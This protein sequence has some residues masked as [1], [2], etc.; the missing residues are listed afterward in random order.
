[1][2]GCWATDGGWLTTRPGNSGDRLRE[3]RLPDMACLCHPAPISFW[4][5]DWFYYRAGVLNW[6]QLCPPGDIWQCWRH[7]GRHSGGVLLV[8]SGRRPRTL[9]TPSHM[10]AGTCC[11]PGRCSLLEL[12]AQ[13][14]QPVRSSWKLH[15]ECNDQ[16]SEGEW[17]RFLLAPAPEGHICFF[18]RPLKLLFLSTGLTSPF[19]SVAA[20]T[21]FQKI[22]FLLAK[23]K[24]VLFL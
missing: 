4:L 12:L 8:S 1:M 5:E 21:S 17:N 16:R 7:S 10:Q 3:E 14:G 20:S 11:R 13:P 18:P 24:V 9:R 23:S 19:D 15:L 6:G 22:P 2:H